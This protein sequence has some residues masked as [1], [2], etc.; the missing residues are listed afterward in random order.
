MSRPDQDVSSRDFAPAV[1]DGWDVNRR[2]A[3]QASRR[4]GVV[5]AITVMLISTLSTIGLIISVDASVGRTTDPTN[6][7]LLA[8]FLGL[9]AVGCL[10]VWHRPA[11]LIGRL[12]MAMGVMA[13]LYLLAF[14]WGMYAGDV[15]AAAPAGNLAAWLAS[16]LIVPAFS[17]APF[18]VAT[19]PT[20]RI[21]TGW[22][23][24]LALP[25][26]VAVCV[27]T[28]AQSL[29][30]EPI[31][32][33][34]PPLKPIANPLGVRSAKTELGILSAVS[35]VLIVVFALAAVGDLVWRWRSSKGVERQQIRW[36]M[37]AVVVLPVSFIASALVGLVAGE[38]A[39]DVALGFGQVLFLVSLSAAMAV[40][41]LRFR[42]FDLDRV[43]RRT[44]TYT[45]LSVGAALFYISIVVSVGAVVTASSSGVR[46]AVAA[47][48]VALL[49]TPARARIQ[50]F[51]DRAGDRHRV[52]P[53]QALSTLSRK[54][55]HVIDPDDILRVSVTTI[56]GTLN[57]GYVGIELA[58]DGHGPGGVV[59]SSGRIAGEQMRYPIRHRG[60]LLGHLVTG[61]SGDIDH[62]VLQDLANRAGIAVASAQLRTQLR[63]SRTQLV[64]SR[65]EERLRIRRDLHDG[66]GPTLA[67]LA[68]RMDAALADPIPEI[69]VG[70]MTIIKRDLSSAIEEVR[71]IMHGLRPAAL[72][73]LGLAEALR[74]QA[75]RLNIAARAPSIHVMLPPQLP[76]LPAAI[77]V[78]VLRIAAEAMT[79]AVRHSHASTC[80]VTLCVDE[81]VRLD[82]VDDGVGIGQNQ[83]RATA[84]MGLASMRD[85]AEELGGRFEV[86]DA[87]TWI[88]HSRLCPGTLIS[89]TIPIDT[90]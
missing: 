1:C 42:L 83:G 48:V 2:M 54:L 32:G 75:R 77:E 55:D 52:D 21:T 56:A 49:F 24:R 76:Q 40:A 66:L 10:I 88:E 15:N 34:D 26:T 61:P 5:V 38:R 43:V 16:F 82:V 11:N 50:R 63:N 45:L 67:G 29:A 17:I 60:E 31:D 22:L 7:A 44:I 79:N 53:Y 86:A 73:E 84:G 69:N 51:V 8:G 30:A 64:R 35:V 47:A 4:V 74:Q 85:R 78:A 68:L 71:R 12:L 57:L 36:V 81:T 9:P 6:F 46:A 41:I 65:E 28:I 90:P 33:V 72:D 23:R 87:T 27:L 58:G 19:F 18:V 89:A 80:R 70:Q 37:T 3:H 25:A 20:G 62:S 14:A 59:V 39:H 13:T